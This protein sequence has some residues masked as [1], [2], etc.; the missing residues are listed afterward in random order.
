MLANPVLKIPLHA[1]LLAIAIHALWGGNP[2]AGKF[3]L[4]VFPPYWSAFY[5]FL[6]GI[7]TIALWCWYRGY[8][9]TPTAAEWKPLGWISLLFTLQIGLM[10]LGFDQTSGV[11]AS[12]L[13][14]VNPLFAAVFA[15]FLLRSDQ[16]TWWRS[17]GLVFGFAGVVLTILSIG[18]TG[19]PMAFGNSGDW[20]CLASAA[21][22]GYR[23]IA[24]AE[25]MQQLNPFRL[26]LWQMIL[27]LPLFAIAGG[28]Y[29]TI[30]WT[31]VGWAPVL[32][33]A[34]QGIVVAGLGFM[35]SLWMISRYQPSII[36]SFNFISPVTGVLLSAWLL[37]ET[38]SSLV[39]MGAGLLV[40]GM[41]MVCTEKMER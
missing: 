11:N 17:L 26:A 39:V 30:E 36:V 38:L 8:R 22:L 20:F 41:I 10:N 19:R 28:L 18:N 1:V 3:A 9:M 23:L 29:E 27:S 4:E 6:F 14:A 12:I 33:L 13:I 37:S 21:L 16:L 35:G 15:H 2:V 7:V 40:I 24:S 31:S 32:G 25:A 5:R 34:Y